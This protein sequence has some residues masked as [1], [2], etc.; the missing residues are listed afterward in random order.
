MIINIIKNYK[1]VISFILSWLI[2]YIYIYRCIINKIKD[3]NT[4][5][6]VTQVLGEESL[7]LGRYK[8]TTGPKVRG[9]GGDC[10]DNDDDDDEGRFKKRLR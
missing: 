9:G 8:N 4:N 1:R 3:K 2:I 6:F 7:A 5:T 10:G